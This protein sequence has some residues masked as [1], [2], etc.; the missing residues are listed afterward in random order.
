MP[1]RPSSPSSPKIRARRA[2]TCHEPGNPGAP[3]VFAPGQVIPEE[4]WDQFSS[5]RNVIGEIPGVDSVP[6]GEYDHHWST[7]QVL[8]WVND[9]PEDREGRIRHALNAERHGRPG[10]R[11]R[12]F[13]SLRSMLRAIERGVTDPVEI[14]QAAEIGED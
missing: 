10:P 3:R 13:Q 5:N 2:I 4:Y 9:D 7:N 6:Y 14:A 1:T 8:T 12:L 11:E